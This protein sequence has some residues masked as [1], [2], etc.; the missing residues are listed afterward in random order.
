MEH[1]WPRP[2]HPGR[3]HI[4]FE[5]LLVNSILRLQN[6]A[7]LH[8]QTEQILCRGL[9]ASDPVVRPDRKDFSEHFSQAVNVALAVQ[10]SFPPDPNGSAE[11]SSISQSE[12]GAKSH[13]AADNGIRL[14]TQKVP[15]QTRRDVNELFVEHFSVDF[16]RVPNLPA[17]RPYD[18]RVRQN[19]LETVPRFTIGFLSAMQDQKVEL[20]RQN[21]IER[22]PIRGDHV[23]Q[24]SEFSPGIRCIHRNLL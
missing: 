11:N 9:A 20:I 1:N 24:Y 14:E 18:F 13:F 4:S 16:L 5:S 15:E 21:G 3:L 17:Q 12:H 6:P 23:R 19:L 2:N 22:K 7:T 8:A 10:R